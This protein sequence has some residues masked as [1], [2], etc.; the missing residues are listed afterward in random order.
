M[1][2]LS[3]EKLLAKWNQ[4]EKV[5]NE[6]QTVAAKAFAKTPIHQKSTVKGNEEGVKNAPSKFDGKGGKMEKTDTKSK[7][8]AEKAADEFE[9]NKKAA[10]KDEGNDNKEGSEGGAKVATS[11]GAYAASNFRSKLRGIFGTPKHNEPNMGKSGLTEGRKPSAQKEKPAPVEKTDYDKLFKEI[12]AQ[13]MRKDTAIAALTKAMEAAASDEEKS[14]F[15]EMIQGLET[16]KNRILTQLTTTQASAQDQMDVQKLMGANTASA[17]EAGET[18]AHEAGESPAE[19]NAEDA[20][21]EAGETATHE[22]GESE[23][24]E[25]KEHGEK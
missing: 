20:E 10:G 25:E 19:E 6:E 13:L 1:S 24:E 14:E 17:E 8:G 3:K 22:A 9:G 11:K 5:L 15:G 18:Q 16:Q 23:E 12:K 21:E 4:L 2:S 7:P